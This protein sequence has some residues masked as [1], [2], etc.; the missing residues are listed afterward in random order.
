MRFTLP[1][2]IAALTA[3]AVLAAPA[4]ETRQPL[5]DNATEDSQIYRRSPDDAATILAREEHD[6]L[7]AR[8]TSPDLHTNVRRA[9]VRGRPRMR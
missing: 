4:S 5:E 1:A 6:G 7:Q 8:S 2:L 3:T 9:V